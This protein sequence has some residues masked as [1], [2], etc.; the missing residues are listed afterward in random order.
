MIHNFIKK[1]APVAF[2]LRGGKNDN[3]MQFDTIW[4]VSESYQHKVNLSDTCV[5]YKSSCILLNKMMRFN[6]ISTRK[7]IMYELIFNKLFRESRFAI[8]CI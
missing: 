6:S 3:L 1:Q 4:R 5:T 2:F 7:L 8:N